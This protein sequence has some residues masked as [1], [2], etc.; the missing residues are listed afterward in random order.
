MLDSVVQ[1]APN[2][3]QPSYEADQIQISGSFTESEAKDL[4][5]VLRY[6]SLPVKLEPQTVQTVS[7]TLGEDSLQAGLVAGLP[8]RSRSCAST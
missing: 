1:S 5:L 4:A 8:R 7:P 2:I 3:E 6:G